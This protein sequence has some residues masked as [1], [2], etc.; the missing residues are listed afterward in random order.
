MFLHYIDWSEYG[1][2]N[3]KAGWMHRQSDTLMGGLVT[4]AS[5]VVGANVDQKLCLLSEH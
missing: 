4:E 3:K 1:Y 5:S 2:V